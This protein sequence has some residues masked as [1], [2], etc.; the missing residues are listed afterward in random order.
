[1][2]G[3][4]LKKLRTDRN[5]S[6]EELA[7]VFNILKSS[8]SMYE[9]NVRTPSLELAKDMAKYFNVSIDYMVGYTPANDDEFQM[10]ET[11]RRF[12]VKKGVIG[13]EDD[14]STQKMNEILDF[15]KANKRFILLDES[16]K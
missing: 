16:K 5:M 1:M 11:V 6:Q 14:L 3:N 7:N 15:I 2:F 13:E 8:V 4:R 9:N 12:F 10:A